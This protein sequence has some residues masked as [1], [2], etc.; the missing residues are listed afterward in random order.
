MIVL[1]EVFGLTATSSTYAF[2]SIVTVVPSLAQLDDALA[3][4]ARLKRELGLAWE[5]HQ[6][7]QES[8]HELKVS[9]RYSFRLPSYPTRIVSVLAPAVI[10]SS[11]VHQSF[12]PKV[13]YLKAQSLE[14]S[15]PKTEPQKPKSPRLLSNDGCRFRPFYRS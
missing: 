1:N 11:A 9:G 10:L 13:A 4:V 2:V 12:N 3:E 15:M 7:T 14:M 8:F 6:A 5:E